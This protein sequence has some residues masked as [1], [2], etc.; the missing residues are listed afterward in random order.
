MFS[1]SGLV[2]DALCTNNITAFM[3][4]R[5]GVTRVCSLTNY[6]T[7][8]IAISFEQATNFSSTDTSAPK[9]ENR[10][11]LFKG[12]HFSRQFISRQSSSIWQTINGTES[13]VI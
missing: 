3:W 4:L 6:S 11:H 9:F 8:P 2:A 7:R 5:S 13:I 1:R 10:F 12:G